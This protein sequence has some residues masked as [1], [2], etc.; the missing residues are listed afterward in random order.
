MI[1]GIWPRHRHGFHDYEQFAD[2]A[3]NVVKC[4][5]VRGLNGGEAARWTVWLTVCLPRGGRAR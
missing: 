1:M 2:I 3:V 4:A 5:T